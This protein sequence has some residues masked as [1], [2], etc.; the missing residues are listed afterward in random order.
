MMCRNIVKASE[1]ELR[2]RVETNALKENMYRHMLYLKEQ[3]VQYYRH[4]C[5]HFLQ[6]SDR[7][8]SAK[9]MQ[10]GSQLLYDLDLTS[11]E[12]R[13]LK[14]NI[15]VMERMMRTELRKEYLREI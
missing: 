6:H 10:R 8:V 12:L 15:H 5:E 1:E 9:L 14:D 2:S 4:K 13:T 3:Q 11:R 7:M